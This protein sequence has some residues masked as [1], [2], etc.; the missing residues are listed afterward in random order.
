M[1]SKEELRELDRKY[2]FHP[3]VILKDHEEK[4]ARLIVEGEGSKVK[5]IDGNE[6]IDAFSSLWNVVIGHG[7]KPVADAITEQLGKLEY[8]SPFFGFASEPSIELAA[9]VVGLMPE[10]WG[11]GHVMFTCGGSET[12]DTNIKIARLYWATK[13]QDAKKK[14][15]SRDLAY[16]GVTFGALN[17]TG[18]E[19]FK[20]NF[21][22]ML[23]GF[24][25]IM[26]PYCYR[27]ALSLTYPECGIACAKA[28]EERIIEEGPETVAAFIAE[29]VMGTGGVIPPPDEYWPM[30]RDICDKHDVLFIADEVITG[31]GRTGKMFGCMNWDVRP[32]LMSIAKGITSGYFPLG[33]AIASNEIY[34]TIKDGLANMMPFLH[35]FTYNN[36]PTGCAAGLA[37]LKFI[38][39]NKLVENAAEIGTYLADR[40]KGLYDHKSVGDIRSRGLMAAV[41]IVKDKETKEQIGDMPMDSTHRIED[42]MWEKGIYARGMLETVGIAPVLTTTKEEIDLIVDALDASIA[43]MEDEML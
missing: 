42:L 25:H 4:G 12:N 3:V 15:I 28:L 9:K 26:A 1:K 39:D 38:E 37:N 29:P 43:E 16:H 5:D 27:C 8:Y 21:D 34:E 23:P 22:P 17:A 30:I 40:L 20:L 24:S 33:G 7:Q 6:Y 10:E 35:G 19:F 31:F 11:M 18:L 36:H 41:E 2:L 32:D 14:I 13:G